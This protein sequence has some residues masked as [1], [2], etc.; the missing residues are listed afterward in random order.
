M[1]RKIFISATGTC[2]ALIGLFA[3]TAFTGNSKKNHFPE[4]QDNVKFIRSATAEPLSASSKTSF[5]GT[6]QASRKANLFFRV[7]GPIIEVTVKP[8]DYVK[9]GQVIMRIDPRDYQKRVDSLKNTLISALSRLAAM[10]NGD[11]PEDLAILQREYQAVSAKLEESEH[12]FQRIS[13]LYKCKAASQAAH[14]QSKSRYTVALAE[15]EV[16][17]QRLVKAK[18]GARKED[19]A[20]AEAEGRRIATELRIAQDQLNDTYLKAPFSGIITKQLIEKF[21]MA[22]A[23]TPVLV[24]HDISCIE[25]TIDLPASNMLNIDTLKNKEYDITYSPI[26]DRK[27]KAKLKE[28]STEADPETRTYKLTFAMYQPRDVNILPGMTAEVTGHFTASAGKDIKVSIPSSA[29]TT[30]NGS[31]SVWV[32]NSEQTVARRTVQTGSNIDEK[33][34]IV[35]QGLHPGERIVAAGANFIEAG[36][37]VKDINTSVKAKSL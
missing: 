23:S 33:N 34:I 11:R 22:K 28:W 16:I 13:K 12:D 5:P 10:K 25:I 31:N 15:L 14:D 35:T 9:Q 20:A 36:M 19:I 8:G 4:Q 30:S 27:F 32:I 7:S 1:K 29:L 21:E 17:K 18:K 26:P 3:V 37:K 6:V 24:L 2:F